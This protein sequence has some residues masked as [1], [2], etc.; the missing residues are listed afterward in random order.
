MNIAILVDLELTEKSGGHVK[1]WERIC[2][3]LRNKINN[4]SITIF[5]LG[6][7][8][9]NIKYS[10]KINF[11]ILKPIL[12]SRI[13]RVIGVDADY[14]DLF[15]I[16]FGLLFLLKKFDIIHTTDQFFTMSK[17]ARIASKIWKIPLTTSIHTDTPS[18]SKYYIEKVLNSFPNFVSNLFIKKY[19]ISQKIKVRMRQKIAKYCKSCK[20]VMVSD[21]WTYPELKKERIGSCKIE[22]FERGVDKSIFKKKKIIKK[23]LLKKFNIPKGDKI[24]FFSGRIHELK[25]V[26]LLSQIHKL[27]SKMGLKIT[28]ILAGE[29]FHGEKCKKIG[30][31]KIKI[32]GYL[33]ENQIASLCNICDL[34]VFPSLY[35]TGPQVVLEA[36]ACN[37]VCL[38]SPSGG[39]RRISKSGFDGIIINNYD[40]S[41]WVS[42]TK[43]MLL[44]KRETL[45]IKDNLSRINQTSWNDVF[46]NHFLKNWKRI[47]SS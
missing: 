27:L 36:K 4:F 1:F 44:N 14:T 21:L 43:K 47:T 5:F 32:L 26:L 7:K 42:I 34:F 22:N 24:L 20:Y 9:E 11:K 3:S 17:T 2:R 15:P 10:E 12:S 8:K 39:G 33:N 18:Y 13:L 41:E 29:D 40:L 16:N 28:T 19:K 38:V 23:D 31:K 37:A 45:K 25:G 46:D 6:R 35:E 30:G